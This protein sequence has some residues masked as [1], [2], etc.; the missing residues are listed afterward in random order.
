MLRPLLVAAGLAVS[1]LA[2][3]AHATV[4]SPPKPKP[5][6]SAEAKA[7]DKKQDAITQAEGKQAEGQ[8]P[9]AKKDAAKPA[10]TKAAKDQ[11][12]EAVLAEAGAYKLTRADADAYV[13]ALVFCLGHAGQNTDRLAADRST[14]RDYLVSSFPTLP[15]AA[16]VDLADM[17]GIWDRA[18]N[19]W[20]N[21]APMEQNA[22]SYG[23]LALA[24]GEED[25]SK[26]LRWNPHGAMVEGTPEPRR[27]R[28]L[29]VPSDTDCVLTGICGGSGVALPE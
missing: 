10:G 24:F 29:N 9:G 20:Q 12:P 2:G 17:T 11:S 23:V 3:T 28:S 18:R 16:Q 26:I 25:A 14:V 19:E 1:L 4:P 27:P 13:D 8:Q 21:L 15:E 7:P 6:G 22:F 5:V